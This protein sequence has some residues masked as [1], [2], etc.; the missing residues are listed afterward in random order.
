MTRLVLV[1]LMFLLFAPQAFTQTFVGASGSGFSA[2]AAGLVFAA[3]PDGIE[4]RCTAL[5]VVGASG[6]TTAGCICSEPMNTN[7]TYPHNSD[8]ANSDDASDCWSLGDS[9]WISFQNNGTWGSLATTSWPGWGS[10]EYVAEQGGSVTF[11]TGLTPTVIAAGTKTLCYRYYWQI[12]NTFDPDSD[13]GACQ[14]RNKFMEIQYG[15]DPLP[16]F[17]TFQLQVEEN[18]AQTCNVFPNFNFLNTDWDSGPLQQNYGFTP[19]AGPSGS[20]ISECYEKPCRIEM[21][22]VGNIA[23]GESI[24]VRSRFTALVDGAEYDAET[25][26][27]N[28]GTGPNPGLVT[29]WGGNAFQSGANGDAVYGLFMSAIWA[30]DDSGGARWIGCA[31]EVEGIGCQP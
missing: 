31:E 16:P 15:P 4:D 1:A 21:C 29:N 6:A 18:A 25:T 20:I 17:D 10:L 14:A 3:A 28:L 5:G 30:G 23:T 9:N 8:P 11:L 7:T 19:S 12:P 13:N 26:P 2:G 22:V 24:K 27:G